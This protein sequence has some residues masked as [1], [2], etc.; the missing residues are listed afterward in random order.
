MSL[1]LSKF[2]V[3]NSQFQTMPAYTSLFVT[4]TLTLKNNNIYFYKSFE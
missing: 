3:N 2:C 1:I 4:H